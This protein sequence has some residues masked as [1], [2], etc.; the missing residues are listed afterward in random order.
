MR[1]LQ[2]DDL[3]LLINVIEEFGIDDIVS[4]LE[5][6]DVGQ[7]ATTGEDGKTAVDETALGLAVSKELGMLLIKNISRCKASLY[8]LLAELKGVKS[9][10]IGKQSPVQ[11]V[12]DIKELL[13]KE[14]FRDLFTVALES[15]K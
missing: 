7:Y 1:E 4:A 14:E 15:L 3:F 6:L 11:T 10:E 12:K 2:T 13:G 5:K 9:S 8:K